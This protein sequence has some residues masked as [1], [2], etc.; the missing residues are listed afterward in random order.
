MTKY[1][2]A[3]NTDWNDNGHD[4]TE[5]YHY[6]GDIEPLL[7]IGWTDALWTAAGEHDFDDDMENDCSEV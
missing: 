1:L 2:V 7:C 6:D 3:L 5:T 4:N